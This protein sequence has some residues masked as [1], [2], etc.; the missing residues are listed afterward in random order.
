MKVKARGAE[1]QRSRPVAPRVSAQVL[2]LL[3]ADEAGAP[4]R[5][6]LEECDRAFCA[7]NGVD[8]EVVEPRT[9]R[10]HRHV[11]LAVDAAQVALQ[12]TAVLLK[13]IYF[14]LFPA[15]YSCL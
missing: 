11:V 7:L 8:D 2:D 15:F 5:V 14:F 6:L 10:A 13:A 4:D 3:E 9:R 1:E 12:H